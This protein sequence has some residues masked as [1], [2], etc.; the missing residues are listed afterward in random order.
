MEKLNNI[1]GFTIK[2]EGNI[3]VEGESDGNRWTVK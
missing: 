2:L 3:Y 1:D